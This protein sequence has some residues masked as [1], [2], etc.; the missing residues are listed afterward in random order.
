MDRN[1]GY[2]KR[3]LAEIGDPDNLSDV[4]SQHMDLSDFVLAITPDQLD[5][6]SEALEQAAA[7]SDD[8][9]FAINAYLALE[10]LDAR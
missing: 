5:F 7:H 2:I 10:Y 1:L 9:E 4:C 6:V 8:T 3:A